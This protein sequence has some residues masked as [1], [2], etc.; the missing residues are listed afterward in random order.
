MPPSISW[1][2]GRRVF[3]VA[4][5]SAEA[6]CLPPGLPHACSGGDADRA[7]AQARAAIAAGASLLL[8]F[9]LAGGLDPHLR[10]GDLVAGT[11]VLD[12]GATD[13]ADCTTLTLPGA[14]AGAVLGQDRPVTE[15][16][17]KAALH[18][19]TGAA[20]VDMESHRLALVA[21]EAG[22]DLVVLRAVLD[23]AGQ[24]LPPAALVGLGPDGR[25][26]PAPVLR[27]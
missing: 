14:V 17:D 13:L 8:S 7:E 2:S 24:R 10:A 18:Q 4:G 11:R 5:L 26:R 19:A 23:P 3:V 20:I 1:H 9:G 22:V 6:Q 21:A 15:P 27:R 12:G 16:Q 25:M